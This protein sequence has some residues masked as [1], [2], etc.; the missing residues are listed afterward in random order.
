VQS[1][2]LT[3]PVVGGK[4]GQ[5]LGASRDG[6][7][8]KHNGQD[9][10]APLGSKV[11]PVAAG[12]VEQ[13]GSDPRSGR[14]VIVKHSDG[15]TSSYSHLG[16]VTVQRG[17]PVAPGQSVG[18]VGTS[19]NATGPVLHLVLRDANGKVIDPKEALKQRGGKS[20][21]EETKVI[22]GKKYFL[23]GGKWFDNPR[24]E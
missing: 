12:R 21:V 11:T 22:N 9:I 1:G 10:Q 19:G 13:V 8:R 14:F 4:F 2:K 17:D 5:G 6:G 7:S 20:A 3:F 15:S 18:T 23:I 16:D 24:G